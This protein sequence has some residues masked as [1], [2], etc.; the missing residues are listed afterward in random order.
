MRMRH[1]RS[2]AASDEAVCNLCG[3]TPFESRGIYHHNGVN[4]CSGCLE[5]SLG[6]L[7]REEVDKFLTAW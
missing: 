4:I 6:L 7:E 5:L 2:M 3:A 1:R